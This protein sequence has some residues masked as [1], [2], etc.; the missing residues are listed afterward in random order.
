VNTYVGEDMM[1]RFA[2]FLFAVCPLGCESGIVTQE[3]GAEINPAIGDHQ[4]PLALD[5]ADAGPGGLVLRSYSDY[6]PECEHVLALGRTHEVLSDSPSWESADLFMIYDHVF[7][8]RGSVE[9]ITSVVPYDIDRDGQGDL[10]VNYDNRSR[11]LYHDGTELQEWAHQ[12]KM[13]PIAAHLDDDDV[14]DMVCLNTATHPLILWGG[15]DATTPLGVEEGVHT[16]T[17]TL[18]I[19]EGSRTDVVC[20]SWGGHGTRFAN[21][22]NQEFA[23]E[24]K[25]G[26]GDLGFYA[27]PQPMRPPF[28]DRSLICHN[29]GGDSVNRCLTTAGAPC[30]INIDPQ[31]DR[32][33]PQHLDESV[34]EA[35]KPYVYQ[36]LGPN[37]VTEYPRGLLNAILTEAKQ[38]M[39]MELGTFGDAEKGSGKDMTTPMGLATF[40][41]EGDDGG[42]WLSC[43]GNTDTPAPDTCQAY[44]SSRGTWFQV[45]GGSLPRILT[46]NHALAF[47]WSVVPITDGSG[48]TLIAVPTGNQNGLNMSV[49]SPGTPDLALELFIELGIDDYFPRGGLIGEHRVA[50]HRL[51]AQPGHLFQEIGSSSESFEIWGNWSVVTPFFWNGEYHLAFG[52]FDEHPRVLK[53][54]EPHGNFLRLRLRGTE[55]NRNGIGA[56]VTVSDGNRR[57]RQIHG[58]QAT[59]VSLGNLPPSGELHFGVGQATDVEATV[60]WSEDHVDTYTLT[61]SAQP[62]CVELIEGGSTNDCPWQ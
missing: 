19:G 27:A 38:V 22:G 41:M 62:D 58:S 29:D 16:S 37:E 13:C 59:Q 23:P 45:Q 8:Q 15:G 34:F 48:D 5:T 9:S 24:F 3:R 10:L 32:L 11:V 39:V 6:G 35:Y 57:W 42:V 12:D 52:G 1:F 2:I 20:A 56:V 55:H 47:S 43:V 46:K 60:A 51:V 31:C 53:L 21:K 14:V 33:V 25:F 50:L 54:R 4:A 18:D 40:W 17:C 61:A 30:N 36:A 7:E 44:D 28:G 26:A 49:V